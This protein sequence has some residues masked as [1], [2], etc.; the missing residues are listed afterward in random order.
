VVKTVVCPRN[1]VL[2]RLPRRWGGE[3]HS[4]QPLSNYFG[5]LFSFLLAL[6]SKPA[7]MMTG[8]VCGARSLVM[9]CVLSTRAAVWFLHVY[10]V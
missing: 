3:A 5:L 10:A 8:I 2:D 4:M 1:T 7:S 9:Y 6:K